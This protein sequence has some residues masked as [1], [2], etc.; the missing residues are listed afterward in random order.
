[1]KNLSFNLEKAKQICSNQLLLDKEHKIDSFTSINISGYFRQIDVNNK[2]LLTVGN[3]SDEVFDS[4]FFGASEVTLCDD[5]PYTLY[6]YYLKLAGMFSL[7]YK[8]F[9]WFFYKYLINKYHNNKMFSKKLYRKIKPVLYLLDQDSFY[10][11]DTLFEE[12]DS[13]VIRNNL[14]NDNGY[15]NKALRN[16]NIYLRNELTYNKTK[17]SIE[18]INFNFINKD[19][20]KINLKDKY[21]VINL[22]SICTKSSLYKMVN[23]INH[24]TN[25]IDDDGL[26]I[27][28][29]LWNNNMYTE[30]YPNVWKK[31]YQDPS[32]NKFLSKY[33]TDIISVNSYRDFLWE[34][35][36]KEDKVLIYKK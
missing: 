22:A 1:M 15:H 6:Y 26:M 19:I 14:F 16:F 24:L 3:S 12:Y 29:Y 25:N 18:R 7:T 33:I 11:F 9:E 10:F 5:N 31:I 8:E 30:E 13:N 23:I 4:V 2:K 27:I 32:S 36:T 28:G 20:L 35:N 17:H 34:E 21:D